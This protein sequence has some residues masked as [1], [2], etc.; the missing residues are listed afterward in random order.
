[1]KRFASLL[2]LMLSLSAAAADLVG[3]GSITFPTS[4][5]GPAQERFLRGVTILHSFGWKQARTEF[6]AAQELDPDFAMAYWGESLCYNHPLIGERDLDTPREIL[7]RLGETPE[8]RLAKAPT[9]REKGFVAAVEALFFGEDDT[10]ARRRA[11]TAA[12]RSL[13]EAYPDDDEVAAFYA[14][15]L[16]MSAGPAG[17]AMRSNVLAGS[18]ALQLLDR[19]PNHPGAAHYAIH[20]FD[21][22]VHAPLALPAAYV[23]ADIAEKVS[24]ARHMPSHIFIQR[25]MWERV[26]ASNQSAYEAAVDL[27]EPGD[28]LGDMLHSLDW[29]QY[30]DLQRG[31]YDRAA[32][33]IQRSEGVREHAEKEPMVA[34]IIP[35]VRARMAI[36][37]EAWD[38]RPVTDESPA[39]QL[40]ATGLGGVHT[41]DLALAE[42]AADRLSA[43]AEEAS[44]EDGDR[45]YYARNSKPLQIMVK[46]VGGMLA[47]A[48][49]DT[50]AG[51][52]LLAEGVAV[53]ESMRPPN[54][55]PNPLKPVH[56]LHGE[57]L[58]AADRPREAVDAF[59]ASLLRTPNRPLSLRGL[60][61]AH[62][63]LGE[64]AEA[65]ALYGRLLEGWQ[66]RDVAWKAEAQTYLAARRGAMPGL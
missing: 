49:G 32:V 35:Q 66:D 42:A 21:D 28:S 36:E 8:E 2:V 17:E 22:P 57:A 48:R 34:G 39:T 62:A 20:A 30:G 46:E 31:D 56:E 11:Y 23:F 41:D 15:S 5:T 43:L 52:A 7:G 64:H 25:G 51:L 50:D 14:L 29:G 45:S 55:A 33:W 47:I 12:M 54:G 58:L 65:S 10:L 38:P 13:H 26:S 40:L 59:E 27:W 44:A 60:A 37:R 61:R 4:A 1:M 53:A 3:L 19:N 9:E 18:I 6:Q 24:H 16:L 63:A